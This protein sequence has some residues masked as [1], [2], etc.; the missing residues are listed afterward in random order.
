MIRAF[1]PGRVNLIGEHTDH[2]GG[3][4]LPMAIQLGTTVTGS[5]GGQVVQMSSDIEARPALVPLDVADPAAVEPPWARYVA[6]VVAEL[7]PRT[8]LRASVRTTLPVGA[9]LSSSAALEVA[10]ALALGF[11]GSPLELARL[12]RRAEHRA[13]GVPCGL[14]DQLACA[15]SVEGHALRIDC[16]TEELQAI[17]L[18]ADLRLVGVDSGVRRRLEHTPYSERL[19]ELSRARRRVGPL[20]P[21]LPSDLAGLPAGP[22]R[23]RVR[24]VLEENQR[25]DA[26]VRAL[27]SGDLPLAGA[28][29]TEGHH[30]LSQLFE[31]ST[32]AMDQLVRRLA[33]TPGVL[34]A[35]MTGGG[36]GGMV[37][38]LAEPGAAVEGI[39]LVPSGGAWRIEE[40]APCAERRAGG[41]PHPT[42]RPWWQ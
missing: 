2:A 3:L 5:A 8:A 7:R 36:F 29:L 18:P 9:G 26:M 40:P 10:V 22:V 24:H 31:V 11:P 39:E 30:S 15:A 4:C 38:V 12:C 13:T 21:L 33:A 14:L 28:I 37:V 16:A 1:S 35:R 34:G 42:G 27:G 23:R 41:V 19:A 6:G 20:R 25:V 32:P 17:P